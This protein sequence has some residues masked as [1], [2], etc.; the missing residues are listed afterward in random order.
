MFDHNPTN[1]EL[2]EQAKS[3]L[4]EPTP[5]VVDAML[6]ASGLDITQMEELG[7][8]LVLEVVESL[9]TASFLHLIEEALE[10]RLLGDDGDDE[11]FEVS[12]EARRL[13]PERVERARRA[14]VIE[15]VMNELYGST[16][17]LRLPLPGA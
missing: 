17:E 8:D 16:M 1:A 11:D 12:E 13:S 9:P 7:W 2:R 4:V 6:K 3:L 5:A 15:G 14:A 10:Y